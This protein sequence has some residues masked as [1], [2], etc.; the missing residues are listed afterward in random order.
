MLE[1]CF[2]F[3]GYRLNHCN[4]KQQNGDSMIYVNGTWTRLCE[5]ISHYIDGKKKLL[6]TFWYVVGKEQLQQIQT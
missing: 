3:A 6:W 4:E 2:V 5:Q 1:K